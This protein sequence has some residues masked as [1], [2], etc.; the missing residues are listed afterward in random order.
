[1]IHLLPSAQ[2]VALVGRPGM[3]PGSP[4]LVPWLPGPRPQS[5]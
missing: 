1:M 4:V 3:G 5:S 2:G